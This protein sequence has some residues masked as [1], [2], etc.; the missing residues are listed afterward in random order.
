MADWC[1]NPLLTL[2]GKPRL[3]RRVDPAG[4]RGDRPLYVQEDVPLPAGRYDLAVRFTPLLSEIA[5]PEASATGESD[6]PS[7]PSRPP[8][9]LEFQ[10]QITIGL[11]QIT[12]IHYDDKKKKLA[13][14]DRTP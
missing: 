8:L 14:M 1:N 3:H 5:R 10:S 7:Q 13:V 2:N 6:Q 4:A 9:H 11:D 12:L